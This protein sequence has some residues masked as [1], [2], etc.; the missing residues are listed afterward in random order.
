M[1]RLFFSLLFLS[2]TYAWAQP[3]PVVE[4]MTKNESGYAIPCT[5]NESKLS[6]KLD[7][8]DSTVAISAST[9]QELLGTGLI[10]AIDFTNASDYNEADKSIVENAEIDLQSIKICG[11][12]ISHIKAVVVK[13]LSA[14]LVL[15]RDLLSR[16]G[17]FELD[18]KANT[19]SLLGDMPADVTD[20]KLL[21]KRAKA[22]EKGE[23]TVLQSQMQLIQG[24]W[25]CENL[26]KNESRNV[27]IKKTVGEV[28]VKFEKNK[29]TMSIAGEDRMFT[30]KIENNV[31]VFTDVKGY[32]NLK[33]RRLRKGD[34]I[35]DQVYPDKFTLNFY[36]KPYE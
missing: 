1:T 4:S 7:G 34:L 23:L 13:D 24:R 33:L 5:V 2:S 18:Y 25:N 12:S 31:V 11:K 19:I 35:F 15:G 9:V 10:K 17:C 14:P 3:A 27:N 22:L 8:A 30:F 20:E 6:F 29:F 21:K 26:F 36:M 28:L 16:Y 32:P